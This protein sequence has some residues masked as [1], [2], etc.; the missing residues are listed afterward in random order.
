MNE[1]HRA[2]MLGDLDGV[3]KALASGAPIDGIE[4]QHGN[5]AL[6]LA[7]YNNHP[8]VVDWLLASG[9]TVDARD[10]EHNTALMKAAWSGATSCVDRLVGRG[11][12]VNAVEKDAMTPLMIA[13]FHGHLDVVTLLVRAG[14][15]ARRTDGDGRTA[16]RNAQERGHAEIV[17]L[18]RGL[19]DSSQLPES[20]AGTVRISEASMNFD[21]ADVNPFLE[22]VSRRIE[23][24]FSADVAR[25]LA[26]Q[27]AVLGVD[28]EGSWTYDVVFNGTEMTFTVTAFM[29]DVDAPDLAMFAPLGLIEVIEAEVGVA[30]FSPGAGFIHRRRRS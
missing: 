8:S 17:A 7:A 9:A 2:A 21:L 10:H 19:P 18:L 11:A 1:L 6:M 16:L 24:G 26:S 28:D 15:D 14:A 4:K 27:I 25:D 5:T 29:D 22:S 3:R 12:D 20:A 30:A 23:K 13:A